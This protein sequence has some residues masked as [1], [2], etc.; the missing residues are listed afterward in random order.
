MNAFGEGVGQESSIKGYTKT[1]YDG[2]FKTCKADQYVL[3]YAIFDLHVE[4]LTPR[5]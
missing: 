4:V 2:K 5:T 3:H 1:F